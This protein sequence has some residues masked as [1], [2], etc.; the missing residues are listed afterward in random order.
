M[1][2]PI[3]ALALDAL[4]VTNLVGEGFETKSHGDKIKLRRGLKIRAEGELE[5][6]A[7]SMAELETPNKN[8][9][10]LYGPAQIGIYHDGEKNL[11]V[12]LQRGRMRWITKS[13]ENLPKVSKVSLR[14]DLVEMEVGSQHS[15]KSDVGLMYDPLVPRVEVY[16][17]SGKSILRVRESFET[18]NL[19]GKQKAYFQGVMDGGQIAYDIL[20]KGKRIPRGVLSEALPLPAA[21]EK[22]FEVRKKV[23]VKVL[24]AEEKRR[25]QGILCQ[26]PGGSLN[27]CAWICE[28]A[29]KAA[30]GRKDCPTERTGVDC[31]RRKC[32][33]NGKWSDEF[34][35]PKVAGK[36][37]CSGQALVAACDY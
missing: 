3:S 24:S 34:I 15:E 37:K 35:L 28:G 25:L 17:F 19:D 29:M 4:M 11:T 16:N 27:Q 10:H 13:L 22:K 5:I 14:T 18:L 23:A 6:K 2:T 21:D 30:K 36:A 12:V 8:Q 33:A 31:V 32:D 20:L 1:M 7:N 26:N 9:I